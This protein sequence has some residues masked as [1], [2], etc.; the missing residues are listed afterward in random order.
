MLVCLLTGE[1][2]NLLKFSEI[3]VTFGEKMGK[4]DEYHQ[5]KLYTSIHGYKKQALPDS[6]CNL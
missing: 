4:V 6:D 5:L 2:I 1:L 3:T